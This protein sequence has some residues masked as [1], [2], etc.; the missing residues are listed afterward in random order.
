MKIVMFT[1]TYLPHIGG[2]ARS[3]K[4]LE[5][6]CRALGHEVKVVAPAFD[7][8]QESP[9]VIRVPAIQN[10]N[11]SDFSVRLPSPGLIHGLIREFEPDIIHTHHPFLLGDAALREGPRNGIPVVFTHHTLYEQYTHYVPG[12]SDALKRVAIQLATEFCNLCDHVIAPSESITKLLADRGVESP[13]TTV[14][15]GIDVADFA[16]ADGASFRKQ[17]GI[18]DDA[19]LIGHVGRLAHEKNLPFLANALRHALEKNN[20]VHVAIVGGGPAKE[21]IE[22]TLGP[23]RVSITGPLQGAELTAA[24]AAFDVFAFASQSETQGMVLAEAMSASTPVVA[25]DGP[26]VRE[27]VVDGVNGFLLPGDASE[28]QFATRLCQLCDDAAFRE[29][30]SQAAA[31]TAREYDRRKTCARVLEIYQ[32]LASDSRAEN[33]GNFTPWDKALAAISTEWELAA[34]KLSAAGAAVADT[35]ATA[36]RL[37]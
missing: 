20:T 9:D 18:A 3:V 7:G 11:G 27:I 16:N 32:Q 37:D 5:D 28:K 1:N 10:F 33:R 2:V 29:K 4:T 35:R 12:N 6:D 36:A 17:Y 8:A 24:Y 13:V 34:A 30:A 19:I 25:L 21:E 31:E 14:P 26:G 22:K 23:E 15:T